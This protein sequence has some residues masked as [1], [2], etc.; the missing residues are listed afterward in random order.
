AIQSTNNNGAIHV[1]DSADYGPLQ[2]TR[3]V[4]IDGAGGAL[5]GPLAN[6]VATP[7]TFVDVDAY[8]ATF[9]IPRG[10]SCGPDRAAAGANRAPAPAS[11]TPLASP[12][13]GRRRTIPPPTPRSRISRPHSR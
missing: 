3:P 11:P 13:G 4:T 6:G 8:M 9:A 7:D 5:G 12:C 1:V 10:F 2:V